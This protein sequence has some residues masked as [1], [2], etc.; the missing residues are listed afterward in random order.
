MIDKFEILQIEEY[1]IYK[2]EEASVIYNNDGSFN[3]VKIIEDEYKT[4][5]VKS[6][7]KKASENLKGQVGVSYKNILTSNTILIDRNTSTEYIYSNYTRWS[8]T[9]IKYIKCIISKYINELFTNASSKTFEK[10]RKEKHNK[11]AKYGFYKYKVR[12]STIDNKIE[13]IYTCSLL[14]RNDLNGKKYLY[15]IIDIK[16]E[17]LPP[18]EPSVYN[19]PGI[20]MLQN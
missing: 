4:L 9:K 20:S 13:T 3:R 18:C 2:M 6:S 1:D 14:V 11:D 7:Q 16:K 17:P 5:N 19:K 12:F 15:D 10:N 8:K